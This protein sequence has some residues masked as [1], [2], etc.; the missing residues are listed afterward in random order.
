MSVHLQ[1]GVTFQVFIWNKRRYAVPIGAQGE[2]LGPPLHFRN[3]NRLKRNGY[4]PGSSNTSL[5]EDTCLSPLPS[6]AD[7]A[8]PPEHRR[9][10]LSS[11]STHSSSC[12]CGRHRQGRSVSFFDSAAPA[13]AHGAPLECPERGAVALPSIL[14]KG[15]S[16]HPPLRPLFDF[17]Y[18]PPYTPRQ[19]EKDKT[20]KIK[21]LDDADESFVTPRITRTSESRAYPSPSLLN[22]QQFNV[23]AGQLTLLPLALQ[24]NSSPGTCPGT[25]SSNA[26]AGL[27][28]QK[29]LCVPAN[30]CT[31]PVERVS[32]S[33]APTAETTRMAVEAIKANLPPQTSEKDLSFPSDD[34]VVL[35]H[36]P[37]QSSPPEVPLHFMELTALS[38]ATPAEAMGTAPSSLTPEL[39]RDD[40]KSAVLATP[41]RAPKHRLYRYNRR[42]RKRIKKDM[43]SGQDAAAAVRTEKLQL[44]VEGSTQVDEGAKAQQRERH[45][46]PSAREVIRLEDPP[47]KTPPAGHDDV[48][49]QRHSDFVPSPH[50]HQE[51]SPQPN[52][53]LIADSL[54]S[55]T[56]RSASLECADYPLDLRKAKPSS[57]HC[58]DDGNEGIKDPQVASITF[59]S[60][61]SR[62]GCDVCRDVTPQPATQ[63]TPVKPSCQILPDKVLPR[64]AEVNEAVKAARGASHV[65]E[66][67]QGDHYPPLDIATPTRAPYS[68]PA[69]LRHRVREAPDSNSAVAVP[70]CSFLD[71]GILHQTKELKLPQKR[72]ALPPL[73][74]RLV[75]HPLV[76]RN[77]VS[78][79]SPVGGMS[80]LTGPPR[81]ISV[82]SCRDDGRQCGSESTYSDALPKQGSVEC[83]AAE[84]RTPK[85]SQTTKT[86]SSSDLIQHNQSP[87]WSTMVERLRKMLIV[88]PP[89]EEDVDMQR[90][91]CFRS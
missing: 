60:Q 68:A 35:V 77:R 91:S 21:N 89:T 81:P 58:K 28:A 31:E 4:G 61:S 46:V 44:N 54:S 43:Q 75:R 18:E 29:P 85:K 50:A 41:K 73:I 67:R 10:S 3:L 8:A 59:G 57:V 83:A 76:R 37:L 27:R 14:Q 40:S 79:Q 69:Q 15:S 33:P 16:F 87:P 62:G 72:L 34:P 38:T 56:G 13:P 36:A 25:K 88:N 84:S 51:V 19:S 55:A 11:V 9:C 78:R 7:V 17:E 24:Q 22:L 70:R 32:P 1:E 6:Y 20:E 52:R 63:N 53:A 26:A 86:S 47:F 30:S 74:V 65:G 2:Q 64:N 80:P 71:D 45:G 5:S 48:L 49:A 23:A 82:S 39:Q 42:R 66:H 90:L 12:R